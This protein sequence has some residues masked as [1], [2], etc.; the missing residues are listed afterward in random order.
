M[1]TVRLVSIQVGQPRTLGQEGALDVLDRPWTSAIFKSPVAGRLWLG[2]EGLAGDGQADRKHHGGA[3]KA[4]F[5]CAAEHLPFWR[6][7]LGPEVGAGAF[8]ENL[9]VEG[10]TEDAVCVGDTFRCGT[11]RVQV[12]QPRLPCWKQ[13]RRWRVK[14]LPLVTQESGRTGWY[15]RVLE[16]G[17]VQAGDALTLLERPRP[18]WTVAR[19]NRVMHGRPVD[20]AAAAELAAVPEL[21]ESWR[22]KLAGL[23]R[24]E[25]Q[26]PGR[27]L[28]GSA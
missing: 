21:A 7:L 27:R 18:E 17:Y 20:R 6:E 14:E 2:T 26:D 16:P 11:A 9:L 12:S 15:F 1:S 4:V 8:G 3:E 23:A 13:A 24:G 10:A 22:A 5:A 28:T 19:A 25:P